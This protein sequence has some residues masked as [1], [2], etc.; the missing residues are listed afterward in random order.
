M[1]VPRR[2]L[3]WLGASAV[4]ASACLSPTLPLPPPSKPEVEG[5]TAN[6]QV[7]LSGEVQGGA[8][9]MAANLRTKEIRGQIT[10]TDGLYSFWIAAQVG[11]EIVLWYA[12]GNKESP[13]TNFV[14][15]APK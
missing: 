10:G 8:E 1:K 7:R 13:N 3:L 12:V 2:G 5:P 11:D 4:I 9:I 15:K 14:I 6:G